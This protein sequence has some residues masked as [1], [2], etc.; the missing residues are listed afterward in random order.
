MLKMAHAILR[1][2]LRNP[3]FVWGLSYA[4]NTYL[5][6]VWRKKSLRIGS[7]AIVCNCRFGKSNVLYDNVNVNTVE[8]GDYTYIANNS[9][10]SYANIG[11]FC[12]IGPHVQCGLGL[13]PTRDFISTHPAFFSLAEQAGMTFTSKSLFRERELVRIGNDVWI[14]ANALLLDGICVGDGAIIAAGA[15]VAKDVPAYAI[16]GGVPAKLIRYRF[17]PEQILVIQKSEWWNRSFAWIKENSSGFKDFNTFQ[18]IVGDPSE[19]AK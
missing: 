13:H 14:G 10:I 6:Y 9:S 17:S 5:E 7:G 1:G 4:K 11:K 2:A 19:P 15:V 8:L 16:V 18:S 12:S 3:M